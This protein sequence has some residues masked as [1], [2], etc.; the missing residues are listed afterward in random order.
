MNAQRRQRPERPEESRAV[1]RAS[2]VGELEGAGASRA[3]ALREAEQQLDRIARV[4]PDALAA[5]LTLTE[6]GR[7]TGVSR[8]TL[9]ELRGR[10][11]DESLR[12]AILQV[13][14]T[15]G[16]LTLGELSKR[17]HRDESELFSM[18]GSFADAGVVDIEPRETEEGTEMACALAPKGEDLFDHWRWDADEGEAP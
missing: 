9:Y 12:F 3:A 15:S 17:L 7:I 11:Q 2:H 6:V 8:P 4:L 1:V 14:A 10:Y 5:G 16:R 18:V 13:L